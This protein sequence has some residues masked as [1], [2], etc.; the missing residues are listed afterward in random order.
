L[1]NYI[2]LGMF[3]SPVAGWEII[4]HAKATGPVQ[5]RKK[6]TQEEG[7]YL[8]VPVRNATFES[9]SVQ[10]PPP[11]TTSLIV[12]ADTYLDVQ[13]EL[14]VEPEPLAAA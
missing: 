12:G 14:P 7:E 3:K 10:Q 1:T 5:A 8:I 13:P 4:G 2:V 6:V 11:K 9:V